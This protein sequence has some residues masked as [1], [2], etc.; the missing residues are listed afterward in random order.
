MYGN[1]KNITVNNTSP[2]NMFP[3]NLNENDIILA[4]SD[5]DSNIPIKKLSGFEKFKNFFMCEKNPSITIPKKLAAKTDNIAKAKVKF[6]SAAGARRSGKAIP[7]SCITKDPTPGKRPS[8][9]EVSTKIKMVAIKGKYFSAFSLLPKTDAIKFNKN[10]T[11]SSTAPCTKPGI[12]LIFFLKIKAKIN[13]TKDANRAKSKL[14]VMPKSPMLK[15]FSAFN[16]ISMGG[17]NKKSSSI[18]Y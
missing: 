6:R 18:I 10:S 9:F 14:L 12:N 11:I 15:I 7:S 2:A 13:I 16:D 17:I 3:N 5:I 1:K 8:Q 4:I